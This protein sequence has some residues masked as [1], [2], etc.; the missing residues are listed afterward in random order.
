MG[1]ASDNCYAKMYKNTFVFAQVASGGAT[2]P[3]ISNPSLMLS[4]LSNFFS[5]SKISVDSEHFWLR[6][7]ICKANFS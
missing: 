2:A 6:I 3:L 4:Y 5:I 1:V 7:F